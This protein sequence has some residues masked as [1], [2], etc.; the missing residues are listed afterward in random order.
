[1]STN[2]SVIKIALLLFSSLPLLRSVPL[3]STQAA[4]ADDDGSSELGNGSGL[5]FD[6]GAAA[7]LVLVGGVFAGLTIAYSQLSE[8]HRCR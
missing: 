5:W 4:S 3:R 8:R 7:A 6:L 2:F 1:M